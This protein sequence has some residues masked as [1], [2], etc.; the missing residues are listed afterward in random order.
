MLTFLEEATACAVYAPIAALIT[1]WLVRHIP[2]LTR[3]RG[4]WVEAWFAGALITALVMLLTGWGPAVAGFGA[5]G[6]VAAVIYLRG[7]GQHRA[8]L[9]FRRRTV[10]RN[11]DG[12]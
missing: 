6:L 1:E 2:F 9:A 3:A 11:G 5:S 8:G 12:S 10:L 4:W 7:R